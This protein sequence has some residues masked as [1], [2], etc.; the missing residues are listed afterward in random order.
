M[1]LRIGALLL[2]ISQSV[3]LRPAVRPPGTS[4][5]TTSRRSIIH[6]AGLSLVAPALP[7]HAELYS[8]ASSCTAG[9]VCSGS[10]RT[11]LAAYD[12]MLL[13]RTTE[14]LTEMAADT[15][16]KKPVY[17]ECQKL[18]DLVLQ[19]DWKALEASAKGLDQS[20]DSTKKLLAGIKKQDPKIAAK[21]VLDIADDLDVSQFTSAGTGSLPSAP[22][23][24]TNPFDP[25][26]QNN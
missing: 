5:V 4:S 6:A 20:A 17:D 13:K 16:A 26:L 8:S 19:L 2:V 18:V 3:A 1:L 10:G 21:A 12:E 11:A 9:A 15:P 24:S 22:N 14:E 25:R 7:V 23:R